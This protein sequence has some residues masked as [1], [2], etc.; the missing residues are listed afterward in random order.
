MA[1][2]LVIDDDDAVR[3]TVGKFL[4]SDGHE[5]L[6]APDGAVAMRL[7]EETP[8]DL[9]IADLYMPNMD[10]IELTIRLG[11]Q[12]PGVKILAISGGGHVAKH[13]LLEVAQRLGARRTLAKPFSQQELLSLVRELLAEEVDA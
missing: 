4:V 10:G 11:Q 12:A 8:V 13:E 5:V 1:H 3:E 9:V 7:L 2:I 6:E